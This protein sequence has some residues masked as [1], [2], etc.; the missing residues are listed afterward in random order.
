MAGGHSAEVRI[1]LSVGDRV[2]RAAQLGPDFVVLRTPVDHPPA[3]AEVVLTID[4]SES[5]WR[6]HLPGG[7]RAD[8]RKTRTE[9][10]DADGDS[11]CPEP[12][13]GSDLGMRTDF[14]C[15]DATDVV[16]SQADR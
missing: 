6:V 11:A 8:R 13:D 14:H 1:T 9:P 3:T 5:R 15:G 10:V 4:G 16:K 7:I 12:R 2:F